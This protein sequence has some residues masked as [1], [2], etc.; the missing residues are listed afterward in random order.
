MLLIYIN[1]DVA[2]DDVVACL[3]YVASARNNSDETVF[4]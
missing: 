4:L 2:P 3:T 1:F